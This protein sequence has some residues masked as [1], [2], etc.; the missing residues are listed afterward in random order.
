M[1]MIMIL[2]VLGVVT[3]AVDVVRHQS[4]QNSTTLPLI[5]MLCPNSK[6]KLFPNLQSVLV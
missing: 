5:S 6:N 1:Q 4:A 2:S 3:Q